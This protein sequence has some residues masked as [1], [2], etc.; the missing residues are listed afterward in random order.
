MT[1][2]NALKDHSKHTAILKNDVNI[3]C[4]QKMGVL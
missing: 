1:I 2:Q 3:E 4:F